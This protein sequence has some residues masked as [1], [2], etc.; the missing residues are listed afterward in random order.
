MSTKPTKPA[1]DE[2]VF[3]TELDRWLAADAQAAEDAIMADQIERDRAVL[4]AMDADKA[5]MADELERDRAAFAAIAAGTTTSV[6]RV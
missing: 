5:I 1:L 4:D 3:I 2:T 6:E